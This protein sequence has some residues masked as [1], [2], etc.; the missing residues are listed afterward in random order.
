[1]TARLPASHRQEP[2]QESR[3][4]SLPEILMTHEHVSCGHLPL[5][6]RPMLYVQTPGEIRPLASFRSVEAMHEFLSF[7]PRCE[8]KGPTDV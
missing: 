8:T 4:E 2:E 3:R 1:M 6:K 7:N 5:R